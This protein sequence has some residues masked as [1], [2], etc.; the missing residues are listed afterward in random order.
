[1]D[2]KNDASA[3]AILA[4]GSLAPASLAQGGL[5]ERRDVLVEITRDALAADDLGTLRL[6]LNSQHPVD[7]ANLLS[8]L[9]EEDRPLC[10]GLLAESLAAGVLTEFDLPTTLSVVADLDDHAF[11]GIVDEMAPDDAADVLADLSEEHSERLLSLMEDGEADKVRELMEHPEDSGGGIMT[12]RLVAVPQAFTVANTIDQLRQRAH[13]HSEEP[14]AVF[15][16]DTSGRLVGTMSLHRMLLAGRDEHMG[17]VAD[18]EPIT[19]RADMDQEE[20]AE[21]FADFDLLVLPVIDAQGML[22]G[23]VTV[24]DIIDVIHEEATEDN[25]KMGATSSQE[26]E[27]RSVRGIMRR[28]LPWL[29]LCLL[30]T[31]LSGGVLHLFSGVLASLTSLVLFVPAIM[32]MGGN[33]GIQTSTVTVRSLATGV[34]HP[35]E[36]RRTLWRE[37][38]VAAMTGLLLGSIEFVVAYVW[39]GGSLVAPCAGI[40]MSTA[41]V[42]SAVLGATIPIVFRALGIDPAVAS[43]PLITT[44]NDILSLCIYFGVAAALMLLLAH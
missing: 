1:M 34:L 19:V 41:I 37:L 23:Q 40:A 26:L 16:V 20:I 11:F 31:L 10:L 21:I 14:L 9:D 32:A 29:M 38:R 12:S 22:V 18:R 42:L 13:E 6:V 33:S 30:G 39:T 36:V 5:Q 7:L 28:R 8:R 25:L 35:D 44:L 24:D 2:P 17:D 43:G 3:Q 4:A 15:V 27:D